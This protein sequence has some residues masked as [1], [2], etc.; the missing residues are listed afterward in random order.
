MKNIKD[1]VT[2]KSRSSHDA[3][4]NIHELESQLKQVDTK[5]ISLSFITYCI[6]IPRII[7]HMKPRLILNSLELLLK[8]S[9]FPVTQHYDTVFNIGDY[10]LSTLM[11]RHS[12]F[13]SNPI[14][15]CAFLVYNRKFHEDHKFFCYR[16]L[17]K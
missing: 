10:Y 3:L 14:V 16:L 8:A 11:F 13:Q 12:L 17:S 7:L 9:S 5:G 4:Y 6:T 1:Y 15:P 2:R